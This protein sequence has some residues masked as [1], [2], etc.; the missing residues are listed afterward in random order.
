LFKKFDR[1]QDGV[2]DEK[3]MAA[4]EAQRAKEKAKRD[5]LLAKYDT[6]KDG[7]LSEDERAVAKL[8]RERTKSEEMKERLARQK[9]AEQK[10]ATEAEEA[11][12][13][14]EKARQTAAIAAESA[15]KMEPAPAD[16]PKSDDA[17]MMTQ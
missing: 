12:Q 2:L 16:A 13:K 7:K 5:E 15:G 4:L 8:D 1:N 11:R 6:N 3:E 10:T 17:M 14:A 9:A